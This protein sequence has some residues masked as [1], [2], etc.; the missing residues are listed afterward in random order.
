MN[1]KRDSRWDDQAEPPARLSLAEEQRLAFEEDRRRKNA[2]SERPL[3]PLS[4][5]FRN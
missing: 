2:P 5:L 1:D 3:G 4:Y